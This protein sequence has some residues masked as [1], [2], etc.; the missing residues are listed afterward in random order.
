MLVFGSVFMFAAGRVPTRELPI[1]I[2][3][4]NLNPGG[5]QPRTATAATITAPP[6]QIS[7]VTVMVSRKGSIKALIYQYIDR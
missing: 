3:Q 7:H 4:Q 5:D 6:R 1:T 2:L